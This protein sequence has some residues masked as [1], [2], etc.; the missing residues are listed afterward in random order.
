MRHVRNSTILRCENKTKLGTIVTF[1]GFSYL[2]LVGDANVCNL[3][4]KNVGGVMFIT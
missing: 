2:K 4:K 3:R 1:V